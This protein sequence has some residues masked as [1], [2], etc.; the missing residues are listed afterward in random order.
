MLCSGLLSVTSFASIAGR[1]SGANK[2]PTC[3]FSPSTW[4]E[5]SFLLPR[6]H[7]QAEPSPVRDVDASRFERKPKLSDGPHSQRTR[8]LLRWIPFLRV[9]YSRTKGAEFYR[10]QNM[11]PQQQQPQRAAK[12]LRRAVGWVVATAMLLLLFSTVLILMTVRPQ[13]LEREPMPWEKP[14]LPGYKASSYGNVYRSA[15]RYMA[16]MEKR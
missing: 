9:L 6:S 12:A 1:I 7:L 11:T 10:G 8:L 4:L 14:D 16:K 13:S 2:L 15:A 5:D 3:G